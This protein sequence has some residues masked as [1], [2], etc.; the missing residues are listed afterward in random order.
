MAILLAIP[1]AIYNFFKENVWLAILIG[2][3]VIVVVIGVI[4]AKKR[5]QAAYLRWFYDRNRR[6]AELDADD[7]IDVTLTEA[8]IQAAATG[9]TVA[10]G[11]EDAELSSVKDAYMQLLQ[12]NDIL[13]SDE[14][15]SAQN[16][17][18][19]LTTANGISLNSDPM[20]FR[21]IGENNGGYVFYV[22]PDTILVFVEGPEQVVFIAAYKPAA[23]SLY[24][25]TLRYTLRPQ[26]I[27]DK[28]QKP[29]RYYDRYCPIHDAKIISSRWEVTNK[30][31]SRS[32]RGGLLP[33]NNP[34]HFTLKYGK[35]T[36]KLGNYSVDT[37]FSRYDSTKLL[38]VA[39]DEFK[40]GRVTELANTETVKTS[41]DPIKPVSSDSKAGQ[42]RL[43]ERMTLDINRNV[44]GNVFTS[45]T[46]RQE[47]EKVE[48][49]MPAV[50]VATNN[51]LEKEDDAEVVE[52]VE[53]G[54]PSEDKKIAEPKT[55]PSVSSATK[56]SISIDDARSRNR[57]IANKIAQELNQKYKGQYD[58]KVYQV[59]KPRSDWAMQDA[60]IYTHIKDDANN[61]YTIDFNIRTDVENVRT[62]LEFYVWSKQSDLVKARYSGI[63]AAHS[64]KIKDTGYH[65][66]G[67]TDYENE[68]LITMANT[69][70]NDVTALF[71]ELTVQ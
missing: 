53:I 6:I 16:T 21:Y 34:L 19:A 28:T 29:I 46:T 51:L 38:T 56:K 42:Q 24:C 27:Q 48:K 32:F 30:D 47:A 55:I 17:G 1:V 59:R 50:F 40:N 71:A 18:R 62:K 7:F 70:K 49:A 36:V 15:L 26:V 69:L 65:F 25:G 41:P 9:S 12:S 20:I 43:I 10:I 45:V 37:S 39:Y 64:M 61:E 3:V 5:K 31:G 33:E 22:F 8:I 63:I 2:V 68:S 23:L 67:L 13:Q 35:L 52:T 11:R 14:A 58:F 54:E 60:G 4:V 66:V 44:H 57:M